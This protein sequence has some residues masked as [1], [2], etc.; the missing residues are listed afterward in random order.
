[1]DDPRRIWSQA[2]TFETIIWSIKIP[3]ICIGIGSCLILSIKAFLSAPCIRSLLNF[4]IVANVASSTF[5]H[6]SQIIKPVRKALLHTEK[7]LNLK[8][9]FK[10]YEDEAAVFEVTSL[11]EATKESHRQDQ[12][13]K[14]CHLY[15]KSRTA[16][17]SDQAHGASG[18]CQQERGPITENSDDKA[19]SGKSGGIT[20]K[21]AREEKVGSPKP[22]EADDSLDSVWKAIMENQGRPATWQ[23][24]KSNT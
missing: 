24:K 6:Q 4:I 7:S 11:H 3:L 16:K 21:T 9:E 23:L 12:E 1:M 5:H 17:R 10:I 15:S 14:N 22:E 19:L 8:F 2:S 20:R 18:F 13:W